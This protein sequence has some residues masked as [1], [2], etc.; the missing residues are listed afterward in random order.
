MIINDSSKKEKD[1][2]L[3]KEDKN[4]NFLEVSPK[5]R[6]IIIFSL[7]SSL[8]LMITI[9]F[10]IALSLDKKDSNKPKKEKK[11]N[12]I[13]AK[14]N[15]EDRAEVKLINSK[16]INF[17]SSIRLDDIEIPNISNTIL[18]NLSGLHKVEIFFKKGLNSTSQMFEYC[19]KLTEIDLSNLET[20]NLK[21]M[22]EMFFFL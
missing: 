14:Y 6:T 2:L 12:Y 20:K 16:Y 18:F 11:K 22:D 3:I 19:P 1:I 15:E 9:S 8:L 10:M 4:N 17:I 13:F 7:I 5:I 21:N